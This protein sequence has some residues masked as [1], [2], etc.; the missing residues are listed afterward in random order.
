MK[1]KSFG[2]LFIALVAFCI[3]CACDAYMHNWFLDFGHLGILAILALIIGFLF[4]FGIFMNKDTVEKDV[5]DENLRLR[6][7]L[8]KSKEK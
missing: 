7:Q 5:Y 3:L 1:D 4:G 8:R 6:E 2:I